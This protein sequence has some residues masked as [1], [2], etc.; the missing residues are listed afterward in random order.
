[1]A[2]SHKPVQTAMRFNQRFLDRHAG[3]IISDSSTAIVELVA[4]AWD[5]SASMVKIRWP[6]KQTNKLFSIEDNGTG[7]TRDEFETCWTEIDYDRVS[8]HGRFVPQPEGSQSTKPRQAYGQNGRGRHA[9]FHFGSSGYIVRTWRDGT[10]NSFMVRR[11]ATNIITYEHLG[12]RPC[13][14]HGTEIC[15]TEFT[16]V[17]INAISA[18][19][20]IGTR[21]L[22]DPNFEVMI[23]GKKID[24]DDIPSDRCDSEE[25]VLDPAFSPARIIVIDCGDPDRTTKQKGLAWWV[26]R[27]LVGNCNW[28]G[29]DGRRLLDGRSSYAKRYSII[30]LADALQAA[31]EKDW[32]DFDRNHPVWQTHQ[33]ALDTAIGAVLDRLMAAKR[34]ERSQRVRSQL[35]RQSQRMRPLSR[36]RWVKFI[37]EAIAKCPSMGEGELVQLASILA[38]LES[39][40]SQY[41]ILA[42]MAAL[43][44]Q[45]FDR[46]NQILAAWRVEN[47]KIVLDKIDERLTLIHQ[48]RQKAPLKSTHEVHELQPLIQRS[49]WMFGPEFESIEFTSNRGMTE[50][51]SMISRRMGGTELSGSLN[52][53]DFVILPDSTVGVYGR[54]GPGSDGEFVEVERVVIVELKR[55]GIA[56]G[57]AQKD[58]AEI[59]ARELRSRGCLKH[60]KFVDAF[61]LGQ[62]LDPEYTDMSEHTLGTTKLRVVPMR[63]DDLIAKAERRMMNLYRQV[64]T[65]H[66]TSSQLREFIGADAAPLLRYAGVEGLNVDAT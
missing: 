52:R 6:D 27:R 26:G 5:A 42:Q 60:T 50:V 58:Q 20:V 16:P 64:D 14:G 17:R 44:P 24:F 4:N 11:D 63:Y 2:R 45:E 19:T 12:A 57:K 34:N 53:P 32:S 29:P 13:E 38:E 54:P 62:D 35:D 49:L 61:V 22:A 39:S 30:I 9:A 15:A 23:D 48:L 41:A 25:I 36:E 47:M 33:K 46:L 10:E 59:Y 1:M 28:E 18:R 65:T 56:I 43:K 51:L 37:D 66:F 55:P 3:S 7:M 31:V 21:F 8:I 40:D